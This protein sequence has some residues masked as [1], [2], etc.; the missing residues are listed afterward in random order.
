MEDVS[1]D[2][3]LSD[4]YS[5]YD[6]IISSPTETR[7]ENPPNPTFPI[8]GE[9]VPSLFPMEDKF[10][11]NDYISS[12]SSSY[13]SENTKDYKQ[14]KSFNRNEHKHAPKMKSTLSPSGKFLKQRV[15]EEPSEEDYS[16]V[17][18][19]PEPL[20]SIKQEPKKEDIVKVSY[21]EEKKHHRPK[22]AKISH[23]KSKKSP[24]KRKQVNDN[25]DE[26]SSVIFQMLFLFSIVLA[27]IGGI[28]WYQMEK[29][30]PYCPTGQ[31]EI[32]NV[33]IPCP[34]NGYCDSQSYHCNCPVGHVVSRDRRA[35][36][37]DKTVGFIAEE[38]LVDELIPLLE[39]QKGDF[40]CGIAKSSEIE[41]EEIKTKLRAKYH[42]I[43]PEDAAL[44]NFHL[45]YLKILDSIQLHQIYRITETETGNRVMFGSLNEGSMTIACQAKLFVVAWKWYIIALPFIIIPIL[46]KFMITKSKNRVKKQVVRQLKQQAIDNPDSLGVSCL[47]LRDTFCKHNPGLSW[48]SIVW[49]AVKK[50]IL[51]DDKIW[52]TS[53]LINN[54]NQVMWEWH[55]NDYLAD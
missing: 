12:K 9:P 28:Y 1:P 33:C 37:E 25:D 44:N 49:N 26:S 20:P 10:D 3:E 30:L 19:F 18:P 27:V 22:K 46:W 38:L 21:S 54:Q 7:N 31:G 45:V 34:A 5:S 50:D 41:E 55:G 42:K 52:E 32:P 16:P 13:E 17:P 40:E 24:K 29:D 2:T 8:E 39:K 43:A 14:T 48:N 23:K 6:P 53:Q 47:N 35:C 11:E 51:K 4:Q 36:V 15:K